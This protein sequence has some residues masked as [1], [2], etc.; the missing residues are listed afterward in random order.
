MSV[1]LTERAAQHVQRFLNG[2]QGGNGLRVGVKPTSA[3]RGGAILA[4]PRAPSFLAAP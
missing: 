2:P 4:E 1:S 3:R